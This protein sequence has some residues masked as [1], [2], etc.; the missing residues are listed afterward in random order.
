MV[1]MESL[2]GEEFYIFEKPD[3]ELLDKALQ[4]GGWQH[5]NGTGIGR[6]AGRDMVWGLYSIQS[7]VGNY[8]KLLSWRV[9][10][11]ILSH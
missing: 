2:G 1:D 10:Q 6:R 3:G 8:G 4:G 9:I 11:L 5:E 7:A